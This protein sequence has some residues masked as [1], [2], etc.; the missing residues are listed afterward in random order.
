MSRTKAYEKIPLNAKSPYSLLDKS[1]VVNNG[2]L[3]QIGNGSQ[4]KCFYA[5][6]RYWVFYIKENGNGYIGF[7]SC[8]DGVWSAETNLGYVELFPRFSLVFDGTYVHYA[9][10][11]GWAGMEDLSYRMGTPNQ[12]GTISWLT[13]NQRIYNSGQKILASIGV[14]SSGYPWILYREWNGGWAAYE[15]HIIKS[16]TK[17]GVFTVAGGFPQSGW[18]GEAIL[19]LNTT[20]VSFLRQTAGNINHVYSVTGSPPYTENVIAAL[21]PY[22]GSSWSVVTDGGNI[23]MVMQEAVTGNIKHVARISGAWVVNTVVA[24]LAAVVYPSISKCPQGYLMCFWIIGDRL[25]YKTYVNGS[26]DVTVTDCGALGSATLNNYINTFEINSG[27]G[28]GINYITGGG[29]PNLI[30]LSVL[31]IPMIPILD[32]PH[33]TLSSGTSGARMLDISNSKLVMIPE[34]TPALRQLRFNAPQSVY[35]WAEIWNQYF[36]SNGADS[37]ALQLTSEYFTMTAWVYATGAGA[38]IIMMQGALDVSGWQLYIFFGATKYNICFRSNQL[39]S[40][41]G[42]QSTDEV[43]TGGEWHQI[44][45][46]R[47]DNLD[48]AG[49]KFYLDGEP[50]AS[51]QDTPFVNPVSPAGTKRFL[52]GINDDNNNGF[53]GMMAGQHIWKGYVMSAVEMRDEFN[54]ER[55]KYKVNIPYFNQWTEENVAGFYVNTATT[56]SLHCEAG[57]NG[58]GGSRGYSSRYKLFGNVNWNNPM[59]LNLTGAAVSCSIGAGISI[60]AC[61]KIDPHTG[62]GIGDLG[63]KGILI[64]LSRFGSWAQGQIH[65]GASLSTVNMGGWGSFIYKV[66]YIPSGRYDGTGVVNFYEWNLATLVWDLKGTITNGLPTGTTLAYLACGISTE[67]GDINVQSNYYEFTVRS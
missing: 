59:V 8:K 9:C 13:D 56:A 57:L 53:A 64:K 51:I 17:N 12:D 58:G 54:R 63:D 55:S 2:E 48:P 6:G 62:G 52:I 33:T 42:A 34:G 43:L 22:G 3:F 31:E 15:V 44:G 21:V 36:Y 50:V 24:G 26:W 60:L 28:T 20:D 45:M 46:T 7:K 5:Q 23:H 19:A 27:A 38:D 11:S 25:Y 65:N 49:I 29:V 32:L 35:E 14:D 18:S 4:R 30:K 41:K 67:G 61:A 66:D 1:L 40:H 39:G 16:S 37:T 10:T 47:G